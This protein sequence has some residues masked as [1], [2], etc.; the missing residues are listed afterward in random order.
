MTIP[1]QGAVIDRDVVRRE[2][3][4]YP[5]QYNLLRFYRE[6]YEGSGA[7]APWTDEVRV[8]DTVPDDLKDGTVY[9]DEN[10]R[11]AL[12]RHPREG[13]KFLR[14]V[15]QAHPTNKVKSGVQML[16][17]Y[18]TKTQPTYD[19]YPESVKDPSA[20]LS[21]ACGCGHGGTAR[22]AGWTAHRNRHQSRK[23]R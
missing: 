9:P 18:L 3:P 6:A 13:K 1:E 2:H 19:D 20:P 7:F 16:S 23:H 17:G 4:L 8:S 21:P 22:G 11:T 12:Q 15:M 10:R 5:A 14:R